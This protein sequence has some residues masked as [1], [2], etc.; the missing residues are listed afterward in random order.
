M[1]KIVLSAILAFMAL[2]FGGCV[3]SGAIMSCNVNRVYHIP[4]TFPFLFWG[5]YGVEV[6]V[7]QCKDNAAMLKQACND[8][9]RQDKQILSGQLDYYQFSNYQIKDEDIGLISVPQNSVYS[10]ANF[11]RSSPYTYN[12]DTYCNKLETISQTSEKRKFAVN[13]DGIVDF[14]VDVRKKIIK[15]KTTYKGKAINDNVDEIVVYEVAPIEIVRYE[16]RIYESNSAF[17]ANLEQ[18]L[19]NEYQKALNEYE[20]RKAQNWKRR[21]SGKHNLPCFELGGNEY[22]DGDLV[23]LCRDWAMLRVARSG[24]DTVRFNLYYYSKSNEWP[25]SLNGSRELDYE[26]YSEFRQWVPKVIGNHTPNA[27]RKP[28]KKTLNLK[29]DNLKLSDIKSFKEW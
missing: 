9:E 19:E 5:W 28:E 6:S 21:M 27:T 18:N 22:C 16:G 23:E 17:I 10:L 20:K 12:E 15:T 8:F 4:A 29:V 24:Y 3:S 14:S 7:A 11:F 2:G 26:C 25:Y 13:G 1:R